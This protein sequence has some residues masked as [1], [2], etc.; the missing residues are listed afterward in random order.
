LSGVPRVVGKGTGARL[1]MVYGFGKQTNRHMEVFCGIVGAVLLRVLFAAVTLRLL[2]IVALK[3]QAA[4]G[5]PDADEAHRKAAG[6]SDSLYNF[7]T[8]RP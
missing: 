5:W 6:Y 1:S 3:L 7:L 4:A 2:A 8:S